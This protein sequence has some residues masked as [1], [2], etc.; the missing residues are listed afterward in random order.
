MTDQYVYLVPQQLAVTPSTTDK[1]MDLDGALRAIKHRWKL[2]ALI[3]LIF[4]GIGIALSISAPRMYQ[5]EVVL[6]PTKKQATL[7]SSL[8]QLSGMTGM[9][10]ISLPSAEAGEPLAFLKSKD[11]IRAFIVD[12]NLLPILY[13]KR[14]DAINQRWKNPDVKKQPDVRDGVRYFDRSIRSVLEDKKTGLVTLTIKWKDSQQAADWAN[15]LVKRLNDRMRQRAIT[16][17]GRSVSYLQQEIA[18]TNVVSLQQSL[19]RVLE[20]EMQKL[21]LAQANEEF[22]FKVIDAAYPAKSPSNASTLLI[23]F[24]FGLIGFFL[25]SVIVLIAARRRPPA[26]S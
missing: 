18:A 10:G 21:L 25:S 9:A 13:A 3:T 7:S 1:T 26:A 15:L 2:V 24:C 20:S 22:A 12:N 14:W 17:A 5:A 23:G 4:V 8:G 11:F 16:D 19:G 6:I